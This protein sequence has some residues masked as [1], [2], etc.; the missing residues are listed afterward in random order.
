[1]AVKSNIDALAA[2]MGFANAIPVDTSTEA[3]TSEKTGKRKTMARPEKE[4]NTSSIIE[5]A[6][7][8][9][10]LPEKKERKTKHLNLLI[11]E[12]EYDAWKSRAEDLGISLNSFIESV[13]NAYIEQ[14]R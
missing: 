8:T 10:D 2:S 6:P 9:L 1:M 14:T 7:Y 13:M 12:S 4:K 11:K 3:V 5:V